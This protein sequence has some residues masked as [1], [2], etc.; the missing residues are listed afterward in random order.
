MNSSFGIRLQEIDK[1]FKSGEGLATVLTG[2]NWTVEP[3]EIA[4]LLGASG[5]GK[6]TLINLIAGLDL[7]DSGQIKFCL[8]DAHPLAWHKL[9]DFERTR[10]RL[11]HIGVVYQFFNLIPTLT[12]WENVLL[13]L[14][15]AGSTSANR[16]RMLALLEEVDLHEKKNS[17]PQNLS[18]GE[19]QRVA[20]VRS[21]ANSPRLILADEPTGNLDAQTSKKMIDLLVH[22]SNA[23]NAT[24]IVAT[25][26]VEW[27]P[28]AQT[29]TSLENGK[30]VPMT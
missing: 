8:A 26:A 1:A 30:L 7:P 21:L 24:L 4:V 13:P 10:F 29:V 28:A 17:L 9:S 5:S 16:N 27:V 20:I 6:S 25:H 11:A 18:G 23:Q 14:H 3:G 19:Q 2:L 15:L 22:M 12:V